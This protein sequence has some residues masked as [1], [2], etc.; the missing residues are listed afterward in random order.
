MQSNDVRDNQQA[1]RYEIDVDGG[2]AIAVYQRR[3]DTLAFTHTSVPADQ[4]A[5]GLGSALIAG[6]L[7]DVRRRGLKV[8]P[9]CPFVEGYM[10]RHPDTADLLARPD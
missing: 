10:A 1:S 2:L 3:G 9:L 7:A 4:E 5:R 8:L 6:A